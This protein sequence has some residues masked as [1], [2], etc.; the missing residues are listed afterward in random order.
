M[1]SR[2]LVGTAGGLSCRPGER[3]DSRGLRG[4]FYLTAYLLAGAAR[5]RQ[6]KIVG[7]PKCRL[8]D[9]EREMEGMLRTK[10][11]KAKR[12][13]EV[14]RSANRRPQRN[15]RRFGGAVT[16]RDDTRSPFPERA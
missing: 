5:W 14:T 16:A 7:Y 4:Y 3:G 13:T 8:L 11:T 10:V 6:R 9:V 15:T 1:Q 2:R 12:G